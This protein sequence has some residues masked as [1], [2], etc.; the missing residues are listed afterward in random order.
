MKKSYISFD[1]DG[2]LIDLVPS[3]N[4]HIFDIHGIEI[5]MDNATE[6]S[7]E[8][9]TGLS[10][11]QLW[12][13]FYKVYKEI[14][15]TPIFTG[16]Y[17]LLRKLY[18]KTNEPP[19]IITARPLDAASDTYAIVS[20]LMKKIPF[21]LILK[22]PNAYKSQYLKGY[23]IYV[24]DCRKTALQLS[25]LNFVVPLVNAGYNVIKDIDKHRNIFYINSIADLIPFVDDFITDKLVFSFEIDKI[26]KI[27]KR[28]KNN[29]G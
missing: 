4:Q 22:H 3:I 12:S 17:E 1:L 10:R 7:Y 18:E 13:I 21:N 11:K 26:E 29:V 20:R 25:R 27:K 14:N 2:V 23:K 19:L 5:N 15:Q 28:V 16:A 9:S 24:E 8:K 6:H